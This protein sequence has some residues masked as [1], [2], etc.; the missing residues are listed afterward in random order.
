MSSLQKNTLYFQVLIVLSWAVIFSVTVRADEE[1]DALLAKFKA[2]D[3]Y[4]QELAQL[5]Q[6][7]QNDRDRLR[8]QIIEPAN[9]QYE[10]V[11]TEAERKRISDAIQERKSEKARV[12]T[13][14]HGP[15]PASFEPTVTNSIS[16]PETVIDGSNIPKE[17]DFT[18]KSSQPAN[19]D[20]N[21]AAM[22][23]PDIHPR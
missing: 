12:H 7:T 19:V 22:P 4:V 6:P 2:E 1:Q 5:P 13:P 11:K 18:K 16:Q 23:A 15:Q 20:G 17:L 3:R 9:R 8:K 10:Q 21:P 14:A